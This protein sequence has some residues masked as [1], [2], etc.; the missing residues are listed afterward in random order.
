MKHN[1][2]KIEDIY[3]HY[4]SE[5]QS[6][7]RLTSFDRMLREKRKYFTDEG[8]IKT[9][10]VFEDMAIERATVQYNLAK[11]EV[12]NVWVKTKSNAKQ[13]EK[14]GEYIEKI[15]PITFKTPR[16]QACDRLLEIP[17]FDMHF[18]VNTFADYSNA[19][20]ELLEV[21]SDKIYDK[22]IFV[23]GQDMLHNNDLRGHTAK[24]TDIEKVDMVSAFDNAFMFY[25]PLIE[26]AIKQAKEVELIYSKGNHD[27]S[28]SLWFM[29]MLEKLFPQCRCDCGLQ[30][31]KVRTYHKCFIAWSHS[32]K[33]KK[34]I[35][36]N[37]KDIRGVLAT[38]FI[39]EYAATNCREV[40]LGHEHTEKESDAYG[41]TI[42]KQPTLTKI[43]EWSEENDFVGNHQR[44]KI[45][46]YNQQKLK[47]I[48]YVG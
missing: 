12:T 26:T 18:G 17:L 8:T 40:H 25:S 48:L 3:N 10:T 16:K 1:G 32:D 19:Q 41:F 42:R 14:L 33:G 47:N 11:D 31:I 30:D 21:I 15:K 36:G 6:D 7:M 43:D 46:E 5:T 20:M 29:K 37:A 23:I 13:I 2:R 28:T 27:E 4:V 34:S 44:F 22:I 24:G 39:K 35:P 45:Y 38:R 9:K